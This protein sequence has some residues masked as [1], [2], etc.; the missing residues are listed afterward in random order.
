M[1]EDPFGVILL[2][3]LM[4]IMFTVIRILL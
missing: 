3:A 2:F 1:S 4:A